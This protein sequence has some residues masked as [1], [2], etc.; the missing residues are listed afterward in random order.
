MAI[1]HSIGIRKDT[2]RIF[3][4]LWSLSSAF[5]D[6]N[7]YRTRTRTQGAFPQAKDP[8][9]LMISP[10]GFSSP[11]SPSRIWL[12]PK[13]PQAAAVLFFGPLHTS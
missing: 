1:G 9:Y 3:T 6:M 11:S 8:N 4:L 2:L 13:G 10:L 12:P 7:L 5:V